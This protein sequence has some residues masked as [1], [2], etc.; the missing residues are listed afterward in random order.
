MTDT[1]RAGWVGLAYLIAVLLVGLN[2]VV[3]LWGSPAPSWSGL[4]TGSGLPGGQGLALLAVLG[5]VSA[6][7]CVRSYPPTR[8]QTMMIAA[9]A[10]WGLGPALSMTLLGTLHDTRIYLVAVIGVCACATASA[11]P[12]ELLTRL[13]IVYAWIVGWGSIGAALVQVL[14]GWPQVLTGE[15]DP[16]YSRWLSWVGLDVGGPA[17]LNGVSP[18]RVFLGMTCAVIA[19][20][21]LFALGRPRRLSGWLMLLGLLLALLWSFSRAGYLGLGIGICAALIPWSR[22]RLWVLLAALWAVMMLPLVAGLG[23]GP[24]ALPEGTF[25]WRVELW[26]R[27]VADTALFSPLGMGPRLPADPVV[28]HAHQQVLESLATGGWLGLLGFVAFVVVAAAIARESARRSVVAVLF[29]SAAMWS[30][31]VFTFSATSYVLNG[32]FV[33]LLAVV[34]GAGRRG[35]DLPRFKVAAEVPSGH[36]RDG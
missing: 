5:A 17:A 15:G 4:V 36:D 34:A 19:G 22:W 25:G 32:A 9:V 6:V 16:R 2:Y 12:G 8:L 18:G 10:V 29:A 35:P 7:Y 28:G 26:Q 1:R 24:A 23:L 3:F 13:L 30:I 27:Y 14:T 20:Y 21:L 11:V 33:V 31:D